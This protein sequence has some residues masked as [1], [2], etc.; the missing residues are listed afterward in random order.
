ATGAAS[1]TA[2]TGNFRGR[3]TRNDRL[4]RDQP[5]PAAGVRRRRHLRRRG[6][7]ADRLGREAVPL[8]AEP[9]QAMT[10]GQKAAGAGF[11]AIALSVLGVVFAPQA[12]PVL[13][14]VFGKLELFAKLPL[15]DDVLL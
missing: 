2:P 1:R 7:A 12:L 4:D 10:T 9:D 3:S 11:L 8:A 14:F 5:R 13:Q 15:F 6:A